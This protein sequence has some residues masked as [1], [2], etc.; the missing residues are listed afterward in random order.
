[1]S[2]LLPSMAENRNYHF[3]FLGIYT[4]SRNHVDSCVDSAVCAGIIKQARGTSISFLFPRGIYQACKGM[5]ESGVG[6]D[7]RHMALE[8]RDSFPRFVAG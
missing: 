7:D 2:D 1:M 6:R 8:S 5:M 3:L 4:E